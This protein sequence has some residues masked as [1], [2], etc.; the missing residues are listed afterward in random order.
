MMG[1]EIFIKRLDEL[2]QGYE[3]NT[4]NLLQLRKQLITD[5]VLRVR[6]EILSACPIK[7]GDVV[8]LKSGGARRTVLSI[9]ID[10]Q[11]ETLDDSILLVSCVSESQDP[12]KAIP[13]ITNVDLRVL[14]K[15]EG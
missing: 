10:R 5:E 12:Y 3:E 1:N 2:V 8:E 14:K 9:S 7:I 15:V 11:G 4:K 13:D 6:D